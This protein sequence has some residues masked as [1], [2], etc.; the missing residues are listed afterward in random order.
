MAFLDENLSVF[1]NRPLDLP[2]LVGANPTIA[3]ESYRLE[4]ELALAV[5]RA[6]VDVSGLSRLI[7]VEVK[8]VRAYPQY[9]GH[10]ILVSG[11]GHGLLIHLSF[12]HFAANSEVGS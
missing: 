12:G 11:Q 7:R 5:R 8:T 9:G 10:R 4:P 6:N 3:S 2:D 1:L